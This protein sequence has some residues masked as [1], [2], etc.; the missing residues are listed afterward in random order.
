MSSTCWMETS[1]FL[2]LSDQTWRLLR[3]AI[4][5]RFSQCCHDLF[6]FCEFPRYIQRWPETLFK[7]TKIKLDHLA[8][9]SAYFY[10]R[11]CAH[12]GFPILIVLVQPL[13]LFLMFWFTSAF[14]YYVGCDT[15]GSGS[16]VLYNHNPLHPP[17]PILIATFND[18]VLTILDICQRTIN[19]F[20][21]R[22]VGT[23]KDDSN[24]SLI[25]FLATRT[26]P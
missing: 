12:N 2:P 19:P 17:S 3:K 18:F 9:K 23:S 8:I 4:L 20:G 21:Q 24:Q 5:V 13:L 15:S 14:T 6:E 7:I 26:K 16:I 1:V 25:A 22:Y 11:G 10:G